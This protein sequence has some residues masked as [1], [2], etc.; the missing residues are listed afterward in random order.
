VLQHT[1]HLHN[2]Y[3]HSSDN[4]QGG[5][6][7]LGLLGPVGP[8][9]SDLEMYGRGDERK[10]AC[11]LS[12]APPGCTV[13]S[14]GS[15]GMWQFEEEVFAR[16]PCRI[17]TFDCTLP[18]GAAPP[19]NIASRTRL[20]DVCASG[21]NRTSGAITRRSAGR[22]AVFLDWASILRVADVPTATAPA[23]LKMDIEGHESELLRSMLAAGAHTWPG[24]IQFEY[25]TRVYYVRSKE[26]ARGRLG[27]C[28]NTE[29]PWYDRLATLAGSAMLFEQLWLTAGYTLVSLRPNRL[30][31]GCADVL[32][33]R[34]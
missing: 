10:D 11:G 26:V 24:Q 21:W 4:L 31:S 18:A 19:A 32:L 1:E 29:H 9:C 27:P 23:F 20:H 6:Q 7:A 13:I 28:D 17:E 3:L 25:H 5:V 16:T 2:R 33:A 15:N 8:P 22:P 30:A 12:K 34:R 14:L